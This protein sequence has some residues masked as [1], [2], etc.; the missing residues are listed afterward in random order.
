MRRGESEIRREDQTTLTL[1]LSLV[2][3][4]RQK[5]TMSVKP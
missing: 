5:K 3:E 1:V 2:R 4:R